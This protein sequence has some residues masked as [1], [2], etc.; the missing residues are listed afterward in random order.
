M[1]NR[2]LFANALA[3]LVA[4]KTVCLFADAPDAAA[5]LE[6]LQ[7]FAVLCPEANIIW[8]VPQYMEED[9]ASFALPSDLRRQVVPLASWPPGNAFDCKEFLNKLSAAGV[10]PQFMLSTV[11]YDSH[12][13]WVKDA[14]KEFKYIQKCTGAAY[15]IH[16]K[17]Q[18][19]FKIVDQRSFFDRLYIRRFRL[20]LYKTIVVI[21]MQASK[22]FLQAHCGWQK[23]KK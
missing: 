20:T 21:F 7:N 3:S 10:T 11:P 15:L 6:W 5:N 13:V 9:I 17:F 1:T 8:L 18:G 16:D 19:L 2:Y 23:I 22:I 14:E 4:D 12:G